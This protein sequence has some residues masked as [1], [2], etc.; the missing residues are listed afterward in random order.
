MVWKI[1]REREE[2]E[3]AWEKGRLMEG[4]GQLAAQW[5]EGAEED[6]KV[7]YKCVWERREEVE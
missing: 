4:A 3:E 6:E 2:E 7:D 1:E 5:G